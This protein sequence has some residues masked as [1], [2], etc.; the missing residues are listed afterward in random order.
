MFTQH[1]QSQNAGWHK[2]T[3]FFS[4]QKSTPHQVLFTI[5]TG[6]MVIAEVNLINKFY[7]VVSIMMLHVLL[8]TNSS[9]SSLFCQEIEMPPVFPK[10]SLIYATTVL[11]RW[12]WRCEASDQSGCGMHTIKFYSVLTGGRKGHRT[13][14]QK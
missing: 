2:S 4:K 3:I 1:L 10:K 5:R 7:V 11:Q 8:F 14:M 6:S 13:D 12:R 9:L